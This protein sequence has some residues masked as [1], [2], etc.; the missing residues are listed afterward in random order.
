MASGKSGLIRIFMSLVLVFNRSRLWSVTTDI[1]LPQVGEIIEL[2]A[3]RA[4]GGKAVKFEV[5][6]VDPRTRLMEAK[7]CE[8]NPDG[9]FTHIRMRLERLQ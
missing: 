9:Q 4:P 6:S 3:P 7:A 5:I 2:V 8:A 1:G